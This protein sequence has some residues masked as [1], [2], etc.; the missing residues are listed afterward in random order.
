MTQ[1]EVINQ[2]SNE[3]SNKESSAE[4]VTMSIGGQ[5]FGIPVLQ[6]HD[7]LGRQK[8]TP[9]PLAPSEVAGALNLR[10][11]IV[12]AIDVRRRLNMPP[13]ED[14]DEGMSVVVGLDNELYSLIIDKVGEVITFSSDLFERVPSTLDP[15]WREVAAGIYRQ[16]EGTLVLLNIERLLNLSQAA[17]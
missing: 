16:E 6:V 3:E 11:R 12:T 17:A 14:G 1:Q 2:E 10:G 4:L 5:M 15:R 9:I 13:L 8:I 7:I